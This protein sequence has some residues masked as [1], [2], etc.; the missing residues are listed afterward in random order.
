MPQLSWP[1]EQEGWAYH[2]HSQLGSTLVHIGM[3]NQDEK[4]LLVRKLKQEI[5]DEDVGPRRA[6]VYLAVLEYLG[7]G[8]E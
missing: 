5:E 8:E 7:A 2:V 4:D 6:K 1:S 3:C